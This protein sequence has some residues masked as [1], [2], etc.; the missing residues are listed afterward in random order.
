MDTLT[1]C[2]TRSEFFKHI[3]SNFRT[4]MVKDIPL[5]IFY[6]DFNNFKVVNDMLGHD[7]GD[8][9]LR[10]IAAEIKNVFLGYGNFYRIG[11]DEFI[12][13][14]FGIKDEQS[15][16][17]A[18]RIENVARQAPCGLFVNISVGVKKFTKST[19]QYNKDT[20]DDIV[21]QYIADAESN[22]YLHKKALK[23]AE[24]DSRII[25]CGECPHSQAKTK[26]VTPRINR[27]VSTA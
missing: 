1:G 2:Y 23:T 16:F 9:V 15:K 25:I 12:G 11:G 7:M 4:L 22:M 14:A 5:Y 24:E 8:Q 17:I 27:G 19:Y 26:S 20:I 3:T 6:M 10:S 13:I 21:K 18:K